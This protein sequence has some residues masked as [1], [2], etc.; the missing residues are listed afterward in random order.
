MVNK[1]YLDL[2][3]ENIK[4]EKFILLINSLNISQIMFMM[5]ILYEKTDKVY[6][7]FGISP[8][9]LFAFISDIIYDRLKEDKEKYNLLLAKED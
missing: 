7:L 3:R 2:I 1:E 8:V 4:Y 5:Y 9:I 6:T